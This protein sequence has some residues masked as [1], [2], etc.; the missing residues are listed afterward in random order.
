MGSNPDQCLCTHDLQVHSCHVDHNTVRRCHTR[1]E[2]E[3]HTGKK[4]YKQGIQASFETRGRHHRKFKIR[5]SVA[6]QKGLVSSNNFF[7]KE[8]SHHEGSFRFLRVLFLTDDL[9]LSLLIW[10]HTTSYVTITSC[11]TLSPLHSDLTH[12]KLKAYINTSNNKT[13]VR[14]LKN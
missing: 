6:P 1:G 4:A 3:D 5:V 10:S 14:I 2:S 8:V 7:K 12:I 9:M 11:P 13:L